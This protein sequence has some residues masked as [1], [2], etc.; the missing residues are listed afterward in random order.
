MASSRFDSRYK[1]RQHLLAWSVAGVACGWFGMPSVSSME[2]AA[3]GLSG[4]V[5]GLVMGF[6]TYP[7]SRQ[8]VLVLVGAAA[9]AVLGCLGVWWCRTG[10]EDICPACA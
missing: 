7:L 6:A 1:L 2:I 10:R 8:A 3:F 4:G 9:G 5:V